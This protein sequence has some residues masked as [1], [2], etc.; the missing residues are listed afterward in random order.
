MSRLTHSEQSPGMSH[1]AYDDETT[2]EA[3]SSNFLT[4]KPGSETCRNVMGVMTSK[5]HNI[6]DPPN[7]ISNSGIRKPQ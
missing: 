6:W 5:G 2:P 4:E 3:G 1:H 7:L